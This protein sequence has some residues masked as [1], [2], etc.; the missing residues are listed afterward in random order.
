[1][2]PAKLWKS[3]QLIAARTCYDHLAG[4]YGV[5]LFDALLAQEAIKGPAEMHV[6]VELGPR[7]GEVFGKLRLNLVALRR[8][9]RG[10]AFPC[11]DWSKR[12]PHL[13]EVR[14]R[15]LWAARVDRS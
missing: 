9:R 2:I 12:R 5:A 7:V 14:A 3:P 8:D 6:E 15:S 10:F 4:R 11:P 1:M 13:G